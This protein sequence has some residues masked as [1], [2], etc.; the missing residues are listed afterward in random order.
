[1]GP[2]TPTASYDSYQEAETLPHG[3]AE[4]ERLHGHLAVTVL[5]VQLLDHQHL[6]CGTA[7]QYTLLLGCHILVIDRDGG[8]QRVR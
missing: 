2:A 5:L 8:L 4:R 7:S 3:D 1:M 6:V